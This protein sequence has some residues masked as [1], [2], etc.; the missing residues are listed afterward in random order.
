ML[1]LHS[2]LYSGD[3]T[4]RHRKQVVPSNINFFQFELF[5]LNDCQEY[6]LHLGKFSAL[7]S[8]FRA[9]FVFFFVTLVRKSAEI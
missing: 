1:T 8:H 7:L 3:D 5:S 2:E 4:L 6:F 9:F